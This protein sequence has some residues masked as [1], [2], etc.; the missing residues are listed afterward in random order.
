VELEY[1]LVVYILG[2]MSADSSLYLHYLLLSLALCM[3][4]A[5]GIRISLEIWH[6]ILRPSPYG[7]PCE[8][9][10][11]SAHGIQQ[12]IVTTM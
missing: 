9:D 4:I 6:G 2:H 12:N 5:P 8:T 1:K 11:W 10:T 7:Y 3:Q